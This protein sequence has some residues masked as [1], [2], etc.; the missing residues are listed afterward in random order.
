VTSDDYVIVG[1]NPTPVIR[2][3]SNFSTQKISYSDQLKNNRNSGFSLDLQIP[4]FNQFFQRNRIKI[5]KINL[6][7]SEFVASTTK[8]QLQL[9]IE[10]AYSNM[11]SASESYILLFEQVNAY[12][13]SFGA[14]EVRFNAGVGNSIDYL[15]AKNNLDRANI[16]L[17]NAKYNYVLRTKILDYYKGMRL[18]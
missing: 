5:A 12:T 8:T 9:A 11:T 18:W 3:Q 2:K 1:G 14:A 15:T 13:E 6:K 10:Q 16:A 17:I 7:N 4:I